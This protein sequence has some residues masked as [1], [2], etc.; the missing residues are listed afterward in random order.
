MKMKISLRIIIFILISAAYSSAENQRSPTTLDPIIK[1]GRNI[2]AAIQLMRESGCQKTDLAMGSA[3]P[4]CDI[5]IWR[6]GEGYLFAHYL[7]ETQII[8]HISYVIIPP[9][10]KRDRREFSLT[11]KQFNTKTKELIL[12]F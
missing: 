2:T 10:P 11:V 6:L 4:K 5:V 8:K 3:D 1:V 12:S 9:G 7:L